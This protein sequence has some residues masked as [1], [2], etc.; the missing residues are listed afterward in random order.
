MIQSGL[1]AIRVDLVVA[2]PVV[3]IRKH[4]A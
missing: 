3:S 1:L 4:A 2:E